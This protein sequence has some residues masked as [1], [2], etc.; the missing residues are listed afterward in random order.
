MTRAQRR[1][2]L[3]ARGWWRLAE[4]GAELWC[5]PELD[6]LNRYP[7]AGAVAEVRA[8]E[9]PAAAREARLRRARERWAEQ[10]KQKETDR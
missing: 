7:L 5:A 2:F 3:G 10:Q 6:D 4:P 8:R 1:A 9:E